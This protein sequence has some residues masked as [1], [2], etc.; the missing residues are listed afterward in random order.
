M[1]VIKRYRN[2]RLY[3]TAT[4][5]FIVL[6]DLEAM[7][8]RDEQFK[9]LDTASGRD[10]T[11]SVLTA[12][13]SERVG[14]WKDVSDSGDVLRAVIK[15]GGDRSMSILKNTVLAGIG[16]ASLTKKKAEELIDTLVKTGEV[17]KSEQKKAVM[18]L[19]SK[20]EK[21]TKDATNKVGKE[22]D[23]AWDSITVP[24]KKDFDA[25]VS[26]VD[27]LSRRVNKLEKALKEADK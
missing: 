19:L 22:F 5:E 14:S 21:T 13:I 16:F 17:N 4:K 12:V 20:A 3:N 15:L 7:V 24:R 2:R 23:K 6:A 10:I 18:E 27:R 9:V 26:K 8:R 1:I 25:L 11:L